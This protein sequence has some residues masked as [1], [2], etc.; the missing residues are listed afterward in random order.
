VA[1]YLLINEN[2]TETD[3]QYA[4][5]T[6]QRS[7]QSVATSSDVCDLYCRRITSLTIVSALFL[8]TTAAESISDTS[9]ER[10]EDD[11]GG[12]DDD[13]KS[14]L[15]TIKI[16]FA[17]EGTYWGCMDDNDTDNFPGLFGTL[18]IADGN[19]DT[20]PDNYNDNVFQRS[21]NDNN[22]FL[23][24]L[25]GNDQPFLRVG[26]ST[27]AEL[28]RTRLVSS[29]HDTRLWTRRQEQVESTEEC[30]S[31]SHDI[32]SISGSKSPQS[33]GPTP[34]QILL[35]MESALTV[36]PAICGILSIQN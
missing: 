1:L 33:N 10:N 24:R 5:T 17:V 12:I 21:N 32:D 14:C 15:Q 27:P 2:F 18:F 36:L 19:S 35:T 25:R 6:L 20:N 3:L 34:D 30:P 16:V 22:K 4:A 9:L 28:S 13:D 23:R 8:S 31:C 29:S 11:G 7:Y 26:T